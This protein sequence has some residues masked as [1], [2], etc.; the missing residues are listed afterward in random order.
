MRKA[1]AALSLT[2]AITALVAGCTT[3]PTARETRPEVTPSASQSV[4]S[5]PVGSWGTQGPGGEASESAPSLTVYG[6]ETFF[7]SDGCFVAQGSWSEA[8][9]SFDLALVESATKKPDCPESWVGRADSMVPSED[10]I[11]LLDEAGNELQTLGLI[12]RDL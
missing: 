3:E 9:G 12:S 6:N 7:A 2:A 11:V 5:D 4:A 1:L 8:G 10:S